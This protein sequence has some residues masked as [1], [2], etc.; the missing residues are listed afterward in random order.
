MWGLCWFRKHEQKENIFEKCC[1]FCC[2]LGFTLFRQFSVLECSSGTGR[3]EVHTTSINH[4]VASN[5]PLFTWNRFGRPFYPPPQELQISFT[6]ES[7]NFMSVF[8]CFQSLSDLWKKTH[9]L[10]RRTDRHTHNVE[11]LLVCH[12][13]YT[14]DR[15]SQTKSRQVI[16][17]RSEFRFRSICKV[18]E[19]TCLL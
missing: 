7:Q 18:P 8:C 9:L 15:K 19:T 11:V 10:L 3:V 4:F 13:A 1:C 14:K 5:W 17:G 12:S 16:I 2:C 6:Q